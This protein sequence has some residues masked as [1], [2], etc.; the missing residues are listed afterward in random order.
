[1]AA[2]TRYVT[3]LLGCPS[4]LPYYSY[5]SKIGNSLH[6]QIRT[7]TLP[8]NAYLYQ[9]QKSESPVCPCGYR[10]ENVKHFILNCPLHQNIRHVL[11]SNVSEALGTDCSLLPTTRLT[12]LLLH[13]TSLDPEGG[14]R[15]AECFQSYVKGALAARRAA[16]AADGDVVALHWFD[17]VIFSSQL[18][19][20]CTEAAFHGSYLAHFLMFFFNVVYFCR[21]Y[22]VKHMRGR[23]AMF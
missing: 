10:T 13:G 20:R 7:G 17:V 5:G 12:D 23:G 6:T 21:H 22:F 8:L 14:R 16:A 4:P 11:F 9:I 2:S 18:K 15:V 19:L 3:K 1:M